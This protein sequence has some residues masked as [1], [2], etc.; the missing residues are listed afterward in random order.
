MPGKHCHLILKPFC[1]VRQRL[2][3]IVQ[4]KDKVANLQ[5]RPS[6]LHLD[7]LLHRPGSGSLSAVISAEHIGKCF[8][9]QQSGFF[10]CHDGNLW[11]EFQLVEM[12]PDQ[13]QAKTMES[14][15]MGSVKKG[16]LLMPAHV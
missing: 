1:R 15:N 13:L 10:L 3:V 6:A 9:R 2:T 16:K 7:E 12:R 4:P 8:F 5:L 11:I 14:A